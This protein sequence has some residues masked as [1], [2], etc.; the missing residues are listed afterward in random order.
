MATEKTPPYK[1]IVRAEQSATDWKAKA[2]ERREENEHL[3]ERLE[4]LENKFTKLD[5]LFD[6]ATNNSNA[7]KI[8]VESLSKRLEKANQ[9]IVKQQDEIIELKKSS[10]VR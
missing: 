4:T 8:E 2:T 1:R 10:V 7:L 6:E 3:K 9:T 5:D